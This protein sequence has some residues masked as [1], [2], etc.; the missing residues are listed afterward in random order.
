LEEYGIEFVIEPPIEPEQPAEEETEADLF[1]VDEE[2]TEEEEVTRL[3]Q[4]H[5]G[6][7]QMAGTALILLDESEDQRQVVILAASNEGLSN[8]VNRLLNMIPLNAD[9]A[10]SDCLIQANLAL[11]PSNVFDETVE[12]ELDSSG[13]PPEPEPIEDEEPAPG[14]EGDDEFDPF[15]PGGLA[16]AIPQGPIVLGETVSG[17]LAENESH[18]WTF[19]EGPATIDGILSG[20]DLDGVLE[21]YGPDGEQLFVID[22]GLTGEDE[23]LLGFEVPDDSEYTAV[24]RDFFGRAV[25]YTLTVTLSE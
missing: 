9:Y 14:D 12:Y 15:G 1:A 3:I 5:L 7:I 18:A 23:V 22:N 19:N 25:D 4:S 8:T 10:L 20:V 16:D 2:E 11:C 24:V 17:F 13:V 21:I 6:D